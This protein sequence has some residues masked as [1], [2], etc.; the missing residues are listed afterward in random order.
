[1]YA[2]A[3]SFN[4]HIERNWSSYSGHCNLQ[5]LCQPSRLPIATGEFILAVRPD[6]PHI[7]AAI[8]LAIKQH[9]RL[10]RGCPSQ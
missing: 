10:P 8:T 7:D 6:E 3:V 9:Q 4:V 1:M 2:H 5:S